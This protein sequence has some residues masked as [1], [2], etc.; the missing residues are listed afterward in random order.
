MNR[1]HW[2]TSLFD[3]LNKY[4]VEIADARSAENEVR[5]IERI[6][7]TNNSV[8]DLCC[9]T[10]RHAVLLRK[11]GWNI[12]G[13]DISPN[14]LKVAKDRMKNSQ[15]DYPLVRGEIR[16][17]PFQSGAFTAVISMFTSFGYLPSEGED[18][19]SL[20]EISRILKI[21]GLFLIDVLNLEHL[22]SSGLQKKDWGE[23]PSFFMLEKRV[24]DVKKAQLHS[25]W[26]IINK[27]RGNSEAFEH[28]LRLY[29]LA[30]LRK[31]LNKAG[32]IV[33][34]AY[35]EYEEHD[36]QQDSP[37][38]IV[39]SRKPTYKQANRLSTTLKKP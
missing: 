3:D 14:L 8:L 9:G 10:G 4:W 11:K 22:L 39:L 16:H 15:V 37:R 19:K 29:S 31:I 28:N 12:V 38:L 36:F 23:F 25:K 17:L 13:L 7:E 6:I 34:K 26:V 5:F 33:V 21:D 32:L 2:H 27:N 20:N 18:V 24:L 30:Q 1:Q 35:G